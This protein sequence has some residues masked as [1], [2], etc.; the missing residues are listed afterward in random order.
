MF[1]HKIK[2]LIVDDEKAFALLLE[3]FLSDHGCSVRVAHTIDQAV[4]VMTGFHPDAVVCDLRMPGG[5]GLI[6]LR[7]I[8]ALGEKVSVIMMSAY[9]D[10][11]DFRREVDLEAD[12]DLHK[13]FQLQELLDTVTRCVEKRKAEPIE[14]TVSSP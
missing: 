7:T 2:V 12:A 13:P 10:L 4:H 11:E 6:L 9:P 14:D 8:R 5:S 1:R 3:E